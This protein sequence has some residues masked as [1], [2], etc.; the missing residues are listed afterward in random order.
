MDSKG[1][2][3][4]LENEK[5]LRSQQKEE[6]EQQVKTLQELER[7]L[8]SLKKNARVYVCQPNTKIFFAANADKVSHD[9][10]TKLREIQ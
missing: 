9:T 4:C 6:V 7:E 1:S 2:S 5:K 3:H 10:K 8:G